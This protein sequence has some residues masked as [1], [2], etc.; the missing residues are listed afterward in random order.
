MAWITIFVAT[1][2][3]IGWVVGA[4]ALAGGASGYYPM[5]PV[6]AINLLLLASALLMVLHGTRRSSRY[7]I[8]PIGAVLLISALKL[9]D[10]FAGWPV[11]PDRLFAQVSSIGASTPV[12][13]V[14]PV[15]AIAL[16]GLAAALILFTA[17]GFSAHATAVGISL[18]VGATG[19]VLLV[20]YL[21][22]APLLY[23]LGFAPVALPTAACLVAL[24]LGVAAFGSADVWPITL[25]SGDSVRSRLVR[26]VVPLVLSTMLVVAAQQLI[27]AKLGLSE[28]PLAMS[29]VFLSAIVLVSAIVIRSASGVGDRVDIAEE[30]ARH[31]RERLALA[32][33]AGGSGTFDWDFVHGCMEWSPEVEHLY[34]LEAG[35]FS[36]ALEA[37]RSLVFPED[38]PLFDESV[39]C[40]TETG[41]LSGEWRILRRDNGE[42]RWVRAIGLVVFGD[43]GAPMCMLGVNIDIS[44]R[45]EAEARLADSAHY[46]RGLLEAS[47]DSLVTIS[48]GGKITDVNAA[49]EQITGLSR[50]KIIGTDFSDYFTEQIGRA[51]V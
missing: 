42:L 49:T 31:G 41:K 33:Q 34:G 45:K 6:T 40:A 9:L 23:G 43:S 35:E 18:I 17:K 5:A 26:A 12:G 1:L 30:E 38:V 51:H 22:D 21:Y 14:S 25:F 16:M 15:T 3:L 19:F 29:A 44:E 28:A 11:S 13:N 46:A 8:A 47:L 2:S 20:G 24:S 32:L 27:F 4:L 48:P 36:G 39:K 10:M 7:A 37:W 50:D